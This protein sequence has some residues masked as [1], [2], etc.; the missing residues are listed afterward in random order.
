M[1]KVKTPQNLAKKLNVAKLFF[2]I[3]LDLYTARLNDSIGPEFGT[4]Y[5][6]VVMREDPFTKILGEGQLLKGLY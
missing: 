4:M 1:D 6:Y 3:I 2:Y 5:E